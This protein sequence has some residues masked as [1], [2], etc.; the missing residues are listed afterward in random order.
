M[1]VDGNQSTSCVAPCTM[2][3]PNGRHTVAAELNGY[4]VGRRVFNVPEDSSLVTALNRSTGTL[5]V[6][7]TPPGSRIFI[8]GKLFGETPATLHLSAGR[9]KL[10]LINGRMQHEETVEIEGGQLE[11][12]SV[13]W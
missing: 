1:V 5:V 8:D 7:S 2:S 3:L 10:V 13:R 12:R 6:T 11:S 4:N 9:H